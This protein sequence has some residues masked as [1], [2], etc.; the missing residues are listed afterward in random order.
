MLDFSFF[1]PTRVLFGRDM[2]ARMEDYIP[3]GARVLVLYGG[4]S[5][6]RNGTMERVRSGLTQREMLEFGGIEPNPTFET[7][8]R[9]VA[10]VRE[11]SVDFLIALGGGSVIDGAKFVAAA[12]VW[13]GDPW[14]ILATRGSEIRTAIP[15]AAI[16]TLPATGSEMN[17]T[18]VI[19]RADIAAKRVFKS[20]HVFPVFAVL[21]PTLT[22]TLPPWQIANGIVDAFVHVLEQYLTYPADAPV[23][24]RFAEGLLHVLLEVADTTLAEPENYDA[25]SSLMWAATLALNGLIGAGVP[26]DW[27]SHLIGHELTA[28]YGLDHARTLAV[29][30]PA[31]LSVR[32]EEKRA[33]LIQYAERV[34][35]VREGSDDEKIRSALTLTNEF[36][37]RLGLG[38]HLSDYGLG[39]GDVEALLAA[40]E[41]THGTCA[42]GERQSVTPDVA[43]AVLEAAL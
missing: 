3:V 42:L 32:R 19:T 41:R 7:L 31:M 11:K 29:V 10:L 12:A 34:W 38:I 20:E 33:K 16:P 30:F 40:L 15:L 21:D 25:R 39:Q 35:G 27:S 28:L 4:G 14:G 24:D 37:M 5:V 2:L 22:F 23:Q 17:G 1:N 43:R 18:A 26:Q 13:D 8:M 36:F 6:L 9:A